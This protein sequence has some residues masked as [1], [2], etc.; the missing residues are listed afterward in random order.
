MLQ[1]SGDGQMFLDE[2]HFRSFLVISRKGLRSSALSLRKRLRQTAPCSGSSKRRKMDSTDWTGGN[3]AIKAALLG[4]LSNIFWQQRSRLKEYPD[5][6][7]LGRLI[8]SSK[9]TQ[10]MEA[11][12]NEITQLGE[13]SGSSFRVYARRLPR[14]LGR[15]GSCL[16]LPIVIDQDNVEIG[17]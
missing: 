5:I 10:W 14:Q 8:A 16:A 9:K 7:A 6:P 11:C 12:F 13:V 17:L 3:P 1:R 2:K 15:E 4:W